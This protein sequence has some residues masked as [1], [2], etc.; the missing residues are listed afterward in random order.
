METDAR[1]QAAIRTEFKDC[2]VIMIAHRLQTIIDCDK[3]HLKTSSHL[4][5]LT[6]Y[7][8][9]YVLCTLR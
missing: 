7:L 1:V 6:T 4:L 2:T 5:H 3:V 8:L 9:I